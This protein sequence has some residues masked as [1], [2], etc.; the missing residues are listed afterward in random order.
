MERLSGQARADDEGV[1]SRIFIKKSTEGFQKKWQVLLVGVPAADGDDLI[2]FLNGGVEF[3]DIGL[4]RVRNAV[5]LLRVDPKAG[6]EGFP[7]RGGMGGF[8][9]N[10][11]QKF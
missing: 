6:S 10:R 8:D 1:P 7:K 4:N 11:G 9:S 3:K 2:L 5:D